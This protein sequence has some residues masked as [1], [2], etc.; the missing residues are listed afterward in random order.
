MQLLLAFLILNGFGG[1]AA[2]DVDKT[3]IKLAIR[4]CRPTRNSRDSDLRAALLA[5]ERLEKCRRTRHPPKPVISLSYDD[6]RTTQRRHGGPPA[7]V[8]RGRLK[9]GPS[10]LPIHAS[11]AH[12]PSLQPLLKAPRHPGTAAMAK[13]ASGSRHIRQRRCVD[14]STR[15]AAADPSRHPTRRVVVRTAFEERHDEQRKRMVWPISTTRKLEL[16]ALTTDRAGMSHG[17]GDRDEAHSRTSRCTKKKS[18][19]EGARDTGKALHGTPAPHRQHILKLRPHPHPSSPN[20]QSQPFGALTGTHLPASSREVSMPR[21]VAPPSHRKRHVINRSLLRGTA[22][23]SD[24]GRRRRLV[25]VN[26]K[27]SLRT[28]RV[29]GVR[30]ACIL[31]MLDS[32]R[33]WK[34]RARP[35]P[36]GVGFKSVLLTCRTIDALEDIRSIGTR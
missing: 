35:N 1:V 19:D 20:R 25:R 16:S 30:S 8:E 34:F 10:H 3:P 4:L 29:E 33:T 5:L 6:N 11:S 17:N 28:K 9:S 2:C 36:V 21:L 27:S 23:S 18:V 7:T 24:G 13:A 26:A 32:G 15:Q 22:V 31:R 14:T 12:P